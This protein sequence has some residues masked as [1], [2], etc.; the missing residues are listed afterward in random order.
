MS[1]KRTVVVINPGSG[2]VPG[3]TEANAKDNM[4]A[5]AEEVAERYGADVS[6]GDVIGESDGRWTFPL[7]VRK[8]GKVH[9]HDV[10]MPGL[11]LER[12]CWRSEED[13]SIWDF[14]RLY[15]DGSSWIWKF[16]V[17]V[18]DPDEA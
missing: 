9:E 8:D 10:D 11:P 7:V 2:P 13:G 1:D 4:T 14:P 18:L 17:K 15:V 3:A 5:F 12:V 16:A 6:V